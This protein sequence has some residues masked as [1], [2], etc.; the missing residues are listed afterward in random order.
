MRGARPMIRVLSSSLLPEPV[1]PISRP[2]GPI[3]PC[4]DS[5]RSQLDELAAL[6]DAIG[7]DRRGALRDARP[8]LGGHVEGARVA[9]PEQRRELEVG[10]QRLVRQVDGAG[11]AQRR[12]QPRQA[13]GPARLSWSIR[14]R[15]CCPRSGSRPGGRRSSA[16]ARRGRRHG[17]GRVEEHEGAMPSPSKP[18]RRRQRVAVGRDHDDEGLGDAR[19]RGGIV[20]G[21]SANSGRAVPGAR[22]GRSR[23]PQR[24]G[25][26]LSCGCRWVCGSHFP[27]S[28]SASPRSSVSTAIRSS[29]GEWRRRAGRASHGSGRSR[30]ASP[31][32]SRR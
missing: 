6:G 14:A 20:P 16:A 22:R 27:Q 30:R 2:C 12:E 15:R 25:G 32:N 31:V 19:H 8:P 23:P 10:F 24:P 26:V 7:T 17:A 21:R 3:P 28:H 1:A 13:L 9:H 18:R 5:F 29:S 11:G 4:A